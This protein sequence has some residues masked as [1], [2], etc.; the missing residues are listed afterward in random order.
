VIFLTVER[1]VICKEA[2]SWSMNRNCWAC[3][4]GKYDDWKSNFL[5]ALRVSRVSL[6]MKER[7]RFPTIWYIIRN[8]A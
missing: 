6:N 8:V 7:V 1:K 2:I 3:R 5:A 4:Y